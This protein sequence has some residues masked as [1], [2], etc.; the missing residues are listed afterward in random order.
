M[1]VLEK[2]E[3]SWTCENWNLNLCDLCHN[4][5]TDWAIWAPNEA[6]GNSKWY[7]TLAR[8][9]F[10][11][12]SW[13]VGFMC[14]YVAWCHCSQS[15]EKTWKKFYLRTEKVFFFVLKK[16]LLLWM[17]Q[18]VIAGDVTNRSHSRITYFVELCAS[19]SSKGTDDYFTVRHIKRARRSDHHFSRSQN[20]LLKN[21]R[22]QRIFCATCA[23][24]CWPTLWWFHAVE[25]LS[26][27]NVSC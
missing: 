7:Y 21:Q 1:D 3:I 26:V 16:S 24:T 27:M 5:Y 2:W 12:Q 17:I 10:D 19:G 20:Q 8:L 15:L 14:R 11:S 25:T 4:L 22:F 9:F 6:E 13:G 23:R 18:F